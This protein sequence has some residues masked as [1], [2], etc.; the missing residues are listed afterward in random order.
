VPDFPAGI[1]GRRSSPVFLRRSRGRDSFPSG[2]RTQY[3]WLRVK[4]IE[5]S[6]FNKLI[7]VD[8]AWADPGEKIRTGQRKS[9]GGG[10]TVAAPSTAALGLLAF[11]SRGVAV[12]RAAQEAATH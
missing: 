1:C 3:G 2:K 5:P 6:P 8:Y 10:E 12:L 4:T 11:G 9:G 7:I